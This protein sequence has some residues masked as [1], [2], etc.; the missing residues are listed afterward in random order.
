MIYYQYIKDNFNRMSKLDI[1]I[2]KIG[3]Q[4]AEG[5]K[6]SQLIL[7]FSGKDTNTVITNTLRRVSFDDIPMY[8]F[9]YINIEHN[10]SVYNNDMMRIRIRQLPIYDIKNSLYYLHP[11]YWDGVDYNDKDRDK[12]EKEMSI[13]GVINVYNNTN[14]NMNVTTNNMYYYVEGF[15]IPYPNRNKNEPILIVQLRPNE[16]F[17][18]QIKGCLGVGERDN[19]WAAAAQ[20]YHD[21]LPGKILYTTES[22]GQMN[23]FD[24]LIKSC[25]YI[26]LKLKG[27]AAEIKNRIDEK[28][29]L[30]AQ[31]IF[32]EIVNEDHTICN[33]INNALQDHKQIL[34]SGVSKPDHLVKLMKFKIST[35]DPKISPMQPLFETIEYLDDVFSELMK[36]FTVLKKKEGYDT[37]EYEKHDNININEDIESDTKPKNKKK[38]MELN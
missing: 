16:T 24:I 28:E 3:Y 22:C 32:F 8:A 33:V 37:D 31:T 27:I 19:I 9:A 21:E 29:I 15:Q 18:C 10:N 36:Q 30:P 23:E 4:K 6:S 34:F 12:H 7:E 17:K 5:F 25:L 35:I 38:A 14:E 11:R 13:E 20:S 26:R 2:K 1:N